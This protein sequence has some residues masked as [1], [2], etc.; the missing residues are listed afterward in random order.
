MFRLRSIAFYFSLLLCV[1]MSTNMYAFDFRQL[2]SQFALPVAFASATSLGHSIY[3]MLTFNG[4][5][6]DSKTG[7]LQILYS[8]KIQWIKIFNIFENK[9]AIG[10]PAAITAGSLLVYFKTKNK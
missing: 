3:S 7:T 2:A 4:Y 9:M 5:G 1:P 8:K 10:V 6:F